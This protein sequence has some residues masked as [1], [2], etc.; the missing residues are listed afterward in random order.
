MNLSGY[1]PWGHKKSGMTQQLNGNR[2]GNGTGEPI[3]RAGRETDIENRLGG[4]AGEGEGGMDRE[5]SFGTYTL[6]FLKQVANG[7]LLYDAWSSNLVL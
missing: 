2:K 5:R 6:P 3:H 1:S 4:A 7:E